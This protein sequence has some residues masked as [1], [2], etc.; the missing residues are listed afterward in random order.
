MHKYSCPPQYQKASIR[1]G[2]IEKR[3]VT[4]RA[5]I[6]KAGPLDKEKAQAFIIS[7]SAIIRRT[8]RTGFIKSEKAH[9]VIP[10]EKTL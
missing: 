5:R 7:F 10:V 6:K 4:S 9:K 3:I 8:K 2:T 1:E